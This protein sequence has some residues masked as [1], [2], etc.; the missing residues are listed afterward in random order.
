MIGNLLGSSGLVIAAVALM[1][2]SL[3][4]AASTFKSQRDAARAELEAAE[5]QIAQNEAW[6]NEQLEQKA[7]SIHTLAVRVT[8]L[9]SDLNDMV[10]RYNAE[11]SRAQRWIGIASELQ[12]EIDSLHDKQFVDAISGED[13]TGAYLQIDFSGSRNIIHYT[14]YTRAY[15]DNLP[16][17]YYDISI[18][19]DPI[20]IYSEL[21]RDEDGIWRIRTV[22]GVPGVNLSASHQMD[23]EA[24]RL[25]HTAPAPARPVRQYGIHAGL[26][27]GV[28][29]G[30]IAFNNTFVNIQGGL[31]YRNYIFTYDLHHSTFNVGYH[32]RF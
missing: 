18:N 2:V 22:S 12:A 7:D 26:Y 10:N 9:N 20:P 8:D 28:P 13:T 5:S 17:S 31:Y 6:Y 25:L 32:V 23:P 29:A 15:V 4:I 30:S 3:T 11:R 27:A 14:G 16:A 21:G 19:I 24:F 1:I